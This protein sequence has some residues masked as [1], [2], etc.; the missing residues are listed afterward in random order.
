MSSFSILII[1]LIIYGGITIFLNMNKS[2]TSEEVRNIRRLV[3]EY[4]IE[5]VQI[6]DYNTKWVD[7]ILDYCELH[8]IT[9]PKEMSKIFSCFP[10]EFQFQRARDKEII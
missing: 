1:G 3:Q 4:Y 2:M 8:N 9:S 6:Y 10:Q 7:V 5:H